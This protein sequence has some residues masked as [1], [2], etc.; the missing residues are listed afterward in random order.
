MIGCKKIGHFR[1]LDY[2][3]EPLIHALKVINP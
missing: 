3:K 2:Y 1:D